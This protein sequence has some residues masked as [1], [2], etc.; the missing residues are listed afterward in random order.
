[1]GQINLACHLLP[2]GSGGTGHASHMPPSGAVVLH[3]PSPVSP[4]A[5]SRSGTPRC[6][7]YSLHR[8]RAPH[9]T[10][11]SVLGCRGHPQPQW[12]V[13]LGLSQVGQGYSGAL[14]MG[15]L[16]ACQTRGWGLGAGR[17][18]GCWPRARVL[19]EHHVLPAHSC[20][21]HCRFLPGQV[22]GH[23]PTPAPRWRHARP[24]PAPLHPTPCSQAGPTHT[25]SNP[26]PL[27]AYTRV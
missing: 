23:S 24:T 17:G 5:L 4:Q 18:A 19:L 9:G 3:S 20:L 21:S 12:G 1:M 6:P 27:S 8:S 25:R 10:C 2:T 13:G 22:H 14:A 26:A 16:A 15:L 7:A 11:T